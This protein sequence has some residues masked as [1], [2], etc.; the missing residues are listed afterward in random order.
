MTCH[1]EVEIE[2]RH[3]IRSSNNTLL[4]LLDDL[5]QIIHCVR[6]WSTIWEVWREI[7]MISLGGAR[8]AAGGCILSQIERI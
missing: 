8:S 4:F 2:L 3:I 1:G 5:T 7:Y 6:E